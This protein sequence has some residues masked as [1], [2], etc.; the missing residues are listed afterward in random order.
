MGGAILVNFDMIQLKHTPLHLTHLS[1][2][3]DMFKA[4]IVSDIVMLYSGASLQGTSWGQVLCGI[5]QWSLSTRDKLGTGPLS[6]GER[7][8]G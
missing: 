7:L 8:R 4:K 5:V 2:L 1:G 6:L 3:L